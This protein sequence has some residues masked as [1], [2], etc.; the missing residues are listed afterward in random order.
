MKYLLL[1]LALLLPTGLSAQAVDTVY[2]TVVDTATVVQIQPAADTLPV[3]ST[4]QLVAVVTDGAGDVV[5]PDSLVWGSVNPAIATIDQTG[6]ATLIAK[7][8][9][10]LWVQAFRD[11]LP[12]DPPPPPSGDDEPMPSD[13][14][15]IVLAQDNFDSYD[16]IK[17]G[18]TPLEDYSASPRRIAGNGE[19]GQA[20]MS[21]PVGRGGSGQALRFGYSGAGNE[22]I[23]VQYV[24]GAATHGFVQ[25]YFRSNP[26]ARPE[27]PN[28]HGLKFFMW[29]TGVQRYQSSLWQHRAPHFK[30]VLAYYPAGEYPVWNGVYND[31]NW[32]RM[33]VEVRTGAIGVGYVK[34]WLDGVLIYDDT[35]GGEDR[36]N[37]PH[38][39]KMY[40]N[41]VFNAGSAPIA[42]F[43]LDLDDFTVWKR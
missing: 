24:H 42:P 10:A 40:G 33:T 15:A 25:F 39:T 41:F 29:L 4:L 17:Y 30:S 9:A 43:T 27:D 2:V 36:T 16:A 20:K 34:L 37:I 21:F 13:V 28:H 11:S 7:G 3:G 19:S 18:D 1:A 14:G 6:L 23:W 26:G 35:G 31:G 5:T 32:H 22:D 8:A 12:F 38:T